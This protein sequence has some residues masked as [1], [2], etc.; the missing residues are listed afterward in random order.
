MKNN[1]VINGNYGTK[2]K[3][4]RNLGKIYL[5]AKNYISPVTIEIFRRLKLIPIRVEF[6]YHKNEFEIIAHSYMFR[7]LKPGEKIPEY[8]ITITKN[9]EGKI[10]KVEAKEINEQ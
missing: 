4:H 6:L 2:L 1:R 8:R 5:R 9:E 3:G 7:T 10:E